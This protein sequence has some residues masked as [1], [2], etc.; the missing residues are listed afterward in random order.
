ML[1]TRHRHCDPYPY[2]MKPISYPRQDIEDVRLL[3]SLGCAVSSI[4]S[5]RRL[6]PTDPF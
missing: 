2:G 1:I 3:D 5:Q 6:P 4:S